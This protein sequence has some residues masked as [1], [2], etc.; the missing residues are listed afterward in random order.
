MRHVLEG[1]ARQLG[2]AGP[3][4]AA[5][6]GMSALPGRC[7]VCGRRTRFFYADPL[8]YRESLYCAHCRTTSRYRSIARGLLEAFGLLAGVEA[9]SLAALPQRGRGRR[10]A[11]YDT[12]TPFDTGSSAY[13]IP[14]LLGRCDWIDLS[15][16]TYRPGEEPGR[17]L[18]PR[19][20]CQ[21]IERLTYADESFDIVVMSD[22]ME[23]VRLEE[24]AHREVRRVLRP[25]GIYLFTVPHFRDRPT[26]ERV[27]IVDPDDPSRDVHRLAP[28]YHGDANSP[29]GRAL[30]YR[31][32][33]TDLDEKLR[34]LGFEVRYTSEGLPHTGILRTELFFCWLP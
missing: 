25:G 14:D 4:P 5:Y 6:S 10:L 1:F 31:T 11:V 29:E 22:V 17:V 24:A 19:T 8:Q 12:Q 7:N 34:G 33:G 27:E 15:V 23:H 20:T 16:S 18:G 3:T 13:P 32:F 30:A 2:P 21:N 26:L 9:R 28:E